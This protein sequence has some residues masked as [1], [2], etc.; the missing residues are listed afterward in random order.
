MAG[1]SLVGS[2]P[3]MTGSYPVPATIHG[4]EATWLLPGMECSQGRGRRYTLFEGFSPLVGL[5]LWSLR[6]LLCAATGLSRGV[7][8]KALSPQSCEERASVYLEATR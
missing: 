2:P 3:V 7:T 5:A 1:G 6:G 4:H 8:R